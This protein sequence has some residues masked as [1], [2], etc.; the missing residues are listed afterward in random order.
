MF[1]SGK[2][3]ALVVALSASG[4]YESDFPLEPAPQ[5]AVD[6]SLLGTWRC[7]PSDADPQEGPATVVV[8][9]AR[10]RV[11]SV[12]WLEEGQNPD[13]YQAYA[14]SVRVPRL[15]NIQEVKEGVGSTTWVFARYTLLR[16]H[17]LQ[18]QLVSEKALENVEKSPPAVRKAIERL[19]GNPSLYEDFCVC[20]RAKDGK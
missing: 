5:V 8:E 14:S 6:A 7:L 12:T 9:S 10:E 2:A 16:P 17:V 13:H 15:L 3:I 19:Q 18:L 20:V 11:Y 4:C 1:R